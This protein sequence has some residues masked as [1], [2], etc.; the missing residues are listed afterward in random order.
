MRMCWDPKPRNR[1]SFSSILLHLSIASTELVS[2]DPVQYSD[3]QDNWRKV[4]SFNFPP[5]PQ[6]PKPPN[7]QRFLILI[8]YLFI[9]LFFIL[10]FRLK[11]VQQK[12]RHFS[13]SSSSSIHNERQN[14]FSTSNGNL[15]GNLH[16]LSSK[17][18]QKKKKKKKNKKQKKTSM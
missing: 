8:I 6:T 4:N 10:P 13:S 7:P 18:K 16:Q 17:T 2:Q 5:N 14:Y 12:L 9:Y 15:S 11:E 3:Q 1:P